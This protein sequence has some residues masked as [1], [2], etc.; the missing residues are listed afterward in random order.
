M[1]LLNGHQC[2]ERAKLYNSGEDWSAYHIVQ[3]THASNKSPHHKS[4][5]LHIVECGLFCQDS[6]QKR[7]SPL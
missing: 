3:K 5:W 6:K 7:V 4:F 2:N 1:V